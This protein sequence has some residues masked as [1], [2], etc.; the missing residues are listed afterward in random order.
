MIKYLIV[1]NP[2]NPAN[3]GQI[4]EREKPVIRPS[5]YEISESEIEIY[6]AMNQYERQAFL[7]EKSASNI[8]TVEKKNQPVAQVAVKVEEAVSVENPDT[9]EEPLNEPVNEVIEIVKETIE[10]KAKGRPKKEK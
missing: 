6:K 10:V 4:I 3:I 1:S 8:P 9:T 7:A 2:A 5:Y